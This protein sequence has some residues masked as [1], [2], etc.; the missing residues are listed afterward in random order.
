MSDNK[1]SVVCVYEVSVDSSE[2]S[3]STIYSLTHR[4]YSGIRRTHVMSAE[5]CARHAMDYEMHNMCGGIIVKNIM[6]YKPHD[7]SDIVH[8]DASI[9]VELEVVD[10]ALSIIK[11]KFST[12]PGGVREVEC[13]IQGGAVTQGYI[14]ERTRDTHH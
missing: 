13:C 11:R 1:V 12:Q 6:L 2:W 5:V 10:S 3:Y 9:K 4:Q 7:G 14:R 8:M